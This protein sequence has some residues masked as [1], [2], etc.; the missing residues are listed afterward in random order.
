MDRLIKNKY[1]IIQDGTRTFQLDPE[2]LS[3]VTWQEILTEGLG[4]VLLTSLYY[5]V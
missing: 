4:S 1:F 2:W 5:L 3:D